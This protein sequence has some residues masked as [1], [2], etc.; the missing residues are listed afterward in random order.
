MRSIHPGPAPTVMRLIERAAP[1]ASAGN[2]EAKAGHHAQ[3]TR[4]RPLAAVRR[5][6][7]ERI[8]ILGNRARAQ[9]AS[10]LRRSSFAMISLALEARQASMALASAGRARWRAFS[11]K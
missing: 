2:V 4:V 9:C 1:S 5:F 7:A 11:I 3:H 8:E 10:R 6:G